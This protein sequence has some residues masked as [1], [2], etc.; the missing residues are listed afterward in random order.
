[1]ISGQPDDWTVL[2]WKL[3]LYLLLVAFTTEYQNANKDNY[4]TPATPPGALQTVSNWAWE[5][6]TTFLQQQ[7][8]KQV[9]WICEQVGRVQA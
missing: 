9:N 3:L 8:E 6:I 4:C 1:M 2:G 5:P 7:T